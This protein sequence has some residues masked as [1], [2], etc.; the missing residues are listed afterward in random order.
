[1]A[2]GTLIALISLAVTFLFIIGVPIFLVIGF[3]VAGVSLVIDVTLANLGV[4]LFE[5]LSFFGLLALPLFIMTGDLIN[6]AGIAKR[7]SDFAYS[8]LGFVRGGLGM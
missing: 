1:M 8:C 7:L 4:T 3:W 5:G 2:D 6:A